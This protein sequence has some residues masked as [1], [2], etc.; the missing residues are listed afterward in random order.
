MTRRQSL[1]LIPTSDGTGRYENI[2]HVLSGSKSFTLIS[3]IE[4]LW[5]DR[6]TF[7]SSVFALLII[8]ER[9]HPSATLQRRPSGSLEPVLDPLPA[10]PVPW[11]AS[12]DTPE[13]IAPIVV[14]VKE[15]ETL[16]IPAGWWHRVQQSEG[17]GGLAVAI[18]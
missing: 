17:S 13:R 6:P 11:V 4:G 8:P 3:P 2:Y 9:F 18:N 7:P 15:G 5:L 12:I 16:F 14:T 10:R 1:S